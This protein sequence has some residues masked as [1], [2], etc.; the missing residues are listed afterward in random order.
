MANSIFFTFKENL[1][2]TGYPVS[3]K[4]IGRISG[5]ISIRYN[6]TRKRRFSFFS[7]YN[8]FKIGKGFEKIQIPICFSEK[9][10]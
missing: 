1:F 3:S 9:S 2:L 10:L 8:D 7:S 6:P 4:M 5:Q